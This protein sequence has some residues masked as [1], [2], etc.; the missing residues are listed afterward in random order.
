MYPEKSTLPGLPVPYSYGYSNTT[1]GPQGSVMGTSPGRRER[2]SES[3][4]E[5][6]HGKH[7]TTP[8]AFNTTIPVPAPTYYNAA[9]QG[10]LSQPISQSQTNTMTMGASQSQFS[11]SQMLSQ[12]QDRPGLGFSQDSYADYKSQSFDYQ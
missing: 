5:S 9:S 8:T 2:E 6:R 12:S 1:N 10:Y 7:A 4:R 11:Q 3:K